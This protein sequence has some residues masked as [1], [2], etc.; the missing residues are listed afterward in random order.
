MTLEDFGSCTAC[1]VMT[2]HNQDYQLVIGRQD[3]IIPC[4]LCF[5]LF[6]FVLTVAF[7]LSILFVCF[8][9]W[10]KKKK[11]N[12]LKIFVFLIRKK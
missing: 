12:D 1:S 9:L 6:C 4:F 5:C 10:K 7:V 8:F 11:E 2:D 3:V